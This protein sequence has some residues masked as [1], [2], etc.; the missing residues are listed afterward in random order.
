MG[1]YQSHMDSKLYSNAHRGNE[2][3]HGNSAQ[4][5]SHQP[6]ETKELHRHKRKDQ[7]LKVRTAVRQKHVSK[8]I[9]SPTW[10]SWVRIVNKMAI[11]GNNLWFYWIYIHV[12]QWIYYWPGLLIFT[13]RSVSRFS[14]VP[15]YAKCTVLMLHVIEICVCPF[16]AEQD[17]SWEQ[18]P[19][20]ADECQVAWGPNAL[21]RTQTGC[22][23]VHQHLYTYSASDGEQLEYVK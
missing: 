7:H 6:H 20:S 11:K 23:Y 15:F 8:Q 21:K 22:T 13:Y 17:R 9:M 4:L 10:Q 3:D 18:M 19:L 2:N 5:N 14:W 12:Q 1:T 16:S